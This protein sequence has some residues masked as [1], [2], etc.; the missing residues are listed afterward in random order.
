MH[1]ETGLQV[2]DQLDGHAHDAGQTVVKIAHRD[3]SGFIGGIFRLEDDHTLLG[4]EALEGGVLAVEQAGHDLS[5]FRSALLAQK[6]QIAI[7][8]TAL[9]MLSPMTRR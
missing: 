8:N 4:A 3:D 7:M 1:S 5:V 2:S 6:D 9:I